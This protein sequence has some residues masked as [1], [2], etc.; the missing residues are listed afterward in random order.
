[1]QLLKHDSVLV[2]LMVVMLVVLVLVLMVVVVQGMMMALLVL[3]QLGAVGL[4]IH[5][6]ASSLAWLLL[7]L[8]VV[9]TSTRGQRG[10]PWCLAGVVLLLGLQASCLV[11]LSVRV[12]PSY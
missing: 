6:L 3:Q 12:K 10:L 7:L 8:L 9:V 4:T 2:L 1:L 5:A 11:T